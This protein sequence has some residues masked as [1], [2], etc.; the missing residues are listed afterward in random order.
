M[1]LIF[2]MKDKPGKAGYECFK[3]C[4]E[5]G[6]FIKLANLPPFIC[7]KCMADEIFDKL[8][9]SLILHMKS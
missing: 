3:A 1:E 4:Y 6:F 7:E 5:A 2:A 8:R 9:K